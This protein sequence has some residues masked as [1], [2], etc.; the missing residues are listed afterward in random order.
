MSSGLKRAATDDLL[1]EARGLSGEFDKLSQAVAERAGLSTTELLAMDLISRGEPVTAGLL[2]RELRL[3]TGAI[4]GLID[5]LVR[6]G[7]AKRVPDPGDRRRVLVRPTA[8]ERRI[9]A[10][11]RPLDIRLRRTVAGYSEKDV[12]TLADFIRK[13][14]LAV[15]ETIQ[16]VTRRTD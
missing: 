16:T 6:A 10:L 5:R 8:R 4:T 13:L 9:G 7:F 2:A 12:A 1:L 15:T 3:T 14:R 11:Y